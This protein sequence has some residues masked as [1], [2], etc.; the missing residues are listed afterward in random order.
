VMVTRTLQT[1]A[2]LLYAG[3]ES[4]AVSG[5]TMPAN[6]ANN[7]D[8]DFDDLKEFAKSWLADVIP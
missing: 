6:L 8:V 4:T 1:P 2:Y 5:V 3:F 7:G